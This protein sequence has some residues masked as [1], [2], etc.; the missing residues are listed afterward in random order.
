[1]LIYIHQS[2]PHVPQATKTLKKYLK[3]SCCSGRTLAQPVLGAQ[4]GGDRLLEFRLMIMIHSILIK[5]EL[6]ITIHVITTSESARGKPTRNQE[7]NP[8]SK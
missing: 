5:H 8:N 3:H 2:V 6:F 7:L 4:A 1:M